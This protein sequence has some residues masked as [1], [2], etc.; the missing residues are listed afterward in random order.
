MTG[1][2]VVFEFGEVPHH[3]D[4]LFHYTSLHGVLA[5]L[6][7]G[8][9][10]F[11]TFKN[12]NDPRE[13]KTWDFG[14]QQLMGDPPIPS[15][16]EISRIVKEVSAI[17]RESVQLACF[18]QDEEGVPEDAQFLRGYSRARNWDQY[19]ERHRGACL[20]FDRK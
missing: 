15:N 12:T 9:F 5:I 13:N 16:D 8:V 20:V 10:R 6:A 1:Q 18:T 4:F 19:S 2:S 11:S 3:E 14:I 7:S 17:L